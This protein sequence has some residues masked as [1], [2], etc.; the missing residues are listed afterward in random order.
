MKLNDFHVVEENGRRYVIYDDI[1]TYAY[2][3]NLDIQCIKDIEESKWSVQDMCNICEDLLE[4]INKHSSLDMLSD[5]TRLMVESGIDY[6]HIRVFSNKFMHTLFENTLTKKRGYVMA[7]CMTCKNAY[8]EDIW[9]EWD[10][11]KLGYIQ[12][13]HDGMLLDEEFECD[14]YIEDTKGE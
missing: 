6:E 5:I 9:N 12:R 8:V 13:D 3:M 10:C 4:D 1:E 14:K 7:N 11:R 2:E